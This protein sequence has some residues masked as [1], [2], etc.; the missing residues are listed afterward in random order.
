MTLSPAERRHLS[1]LA[2]R[3]GITFHNDTTHWPH[4]RRGIIETIHA[5]TRTK[6][7]QVTHNDGIWEIRLVYIANELVRR[8]ER[9]ATVNEAT[10]RSFCEQFILD[11]L[12]HKVHWFVTKRL[13]LFMT[14]LM[15]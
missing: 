13:I 9:H 3:Y 14:F 15:H 6:I 10:H 5:I 4:S 8:A 1:A 7:D 12:L 2:K 11:R